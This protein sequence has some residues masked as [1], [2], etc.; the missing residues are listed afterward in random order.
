MNDPRSSNG[1]GGDAK[2]AT[3]DVSDLG[4]QDDRVE[5]PRR[6]L[7]W[8]AEHIFYPRRT[9][10][11][12]RKDFKEN[13]HVQASAPQGAMGL[14]LWGGSLAS[15]LARPTPVPQTHTFGAKPAHDEN[16]FA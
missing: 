11:A 1:R 4:L 15:K 6:G 12:R 5:R 13:G 2:Q 10:K 3:T 7:T 8:T 9:R 16:R 14:R